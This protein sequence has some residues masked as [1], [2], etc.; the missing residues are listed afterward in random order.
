LREEALDASAR[1][2]LLFWKKSDN[3]NSFS[4]K[5]SVAIHIARHALDCFSFGLAKTMI[6]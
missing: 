1:D 3:L 6:C 5:R 4:M 2:F